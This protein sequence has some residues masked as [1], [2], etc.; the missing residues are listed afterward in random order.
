M[1]LALSWPAL[2]LSVPMKSDAFGIGGVSVDADH[3]DAG[4]NRGVDRVLEQVGVG[5]RNENA[6]GVESDGFLK[7][8]EFVFR[9]EGGGAVHFRFDAH[10]FRGVSKASLRFLPVGNVD[11]GGDEVVLLFLGV[12]RLLACDQACARE[13][14]ATTQSTYV[15]VFHTTFSFAH[16]R[17]G[18]KKAKP[19][20][21]VF[22]GASLS[23]AAG[24][25]MVVLVDLECQGNET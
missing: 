13:R 24:E 12:V 3:G 14:R 10:R 5:D 18:P 7:G 9:R 8:V 6:R 15:I 25:G 17:P 23:Q 21:R 4:L 22:W 1:R 20:E 16:V 2:K 11:V 19:G